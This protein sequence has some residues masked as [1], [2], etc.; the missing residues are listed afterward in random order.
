MRPAREEGGRRGAVGARRPV[1]S[2]VYFAERAC[3]DGPKGI[4]LYPSAGDAG[5]GELMKRWT[6][7]AVIT[8]VTGVI[9]GASAQ[10]QMPDM[11]A[12]AKALGAMQQQAKEAPPTVDFRELRTLLPEQLGELKRTSAKGQ[13]NAAMGMA[14]S[15]A[16]GTYEGPRNARA[17]VK[18]ADMGGLGG[19][20]ALAQMGLAADIDS[21]SDTGYERTYTH[22][23]MKVMERYDSEDRSGEITTF[24]DGR[25]SVQITMRNIKPEALKA[26]L[27]AVDVKKLAALKPAPKKE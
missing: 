10:Q 5:E 7:M 3:P 27:D 23:G 24:V 12:L 21:E 15:E 13:R 8:C 26:A 2:G 6:R 9:G 11:E 20:G 16:E 17:T 19:L 25:F 22:K 18:L 4:G 14:V 1:R